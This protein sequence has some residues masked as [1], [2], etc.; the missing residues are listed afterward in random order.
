VERKERI[1]IMKKFIKP[2][3]L[4]NIHSELFKNSSENQYYV[5][6]IAQ[7]VFTVYEILDKLKNKNIESSIIELM[8]IIISGI[9][10]N[11]TLFGDQLSEYFGRLLKEYEENKN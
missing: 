6:G 4:E 1:N 11:K 5:L 2:R 10:A 3:E 9:S 7:G 8:E